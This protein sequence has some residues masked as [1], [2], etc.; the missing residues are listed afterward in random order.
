MKIILISGF[1]KPDFLWSYIRH[2]LSKQGHYVKIFDYRF[3][4]SLE[5]SLSA[6]ERLCG[7]VGSNGP[8]AIIGHSMG[9]L[10]AARVSAEA[11]YRIA[12]ASPLEG[13]MLAKYTSSFLLPSIRDMRPGS[14]Y[15]KSLTDHCIKLNS[16]HSFFK[17][18]GIPTMTKG[19]LFMAISADKDLLVIPSKSAL[20]NYCDEVHTVKGAGHI[21]ILFNAATLEHINSFISQ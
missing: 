5:A 13:T 16:V 20:P 14:D 3:S 19:S 10:L 12:I 17:K 6:L 1:G 21:S 11:N 15:L 8:L 18:P 9:G 7:E 4:D 2:G